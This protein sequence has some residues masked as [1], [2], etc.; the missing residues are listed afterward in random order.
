M[1]GLIWQT[2][3]RP[4]LGDPLRFVAG[5]LSKEPGPEAPRGP[6][7]KKRVKIRDPDTGEWIEREAIA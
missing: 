7:V 6:P 1:L 2:A 3:A 4:P 5:I